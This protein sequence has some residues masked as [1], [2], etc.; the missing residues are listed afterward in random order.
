MFGPGS[1][2]ISQSETNQGLLVQANALPSSSPDTLTLHESLLA[3]IIRAKEKRRAE[4]THH[5]NS[6]RVTPS[7]PDFSYSGA[8]V[9]T[10]RQ[11]LDDSSSFAACPSLSSSSMDSLSALLHQR[12]LQQALNIGSTASLGRLAELRMAAGLSSG[13]TTITT[14]TTTA[15]SLIGLSGA[16]RPRFSAPAPTSSRAHNQCLISDIDSGNAIINKDDIDLKKRIRSGAFPH[17]LHQ[18]LL[19]LEKEGRS[20]IAAFLPHGGAFVVYKPE[21]FVKDTMSKHFRMSRFSSFQRQLNLYDFERVT[22]GPDKGAYY[23]ELFV[24]DRPILST[25]MKRSKTKGVKSL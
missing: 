19:S 18:I 22:D 1:N 9:A 20:D 15:V 23:H 25:M 21:E 8:T 14:T 17:K 11:Q 24:R 6:L 12:S 10:L 5:I 3:E 7:V 2:Q 13:P 4:L 16:S